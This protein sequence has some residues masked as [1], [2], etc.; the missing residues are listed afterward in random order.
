MDIKVYPGQLYSVSV[1][2]LRNGLEDANAKVSSIILNGE[3]NDLYC[4]VV[5]I[6]EE[7]YE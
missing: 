2:V 3:N 4:W 5:F 1:E 7:N 6:Y